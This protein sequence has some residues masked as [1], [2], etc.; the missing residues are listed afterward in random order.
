MKQRAIAALAA[1]VLAAT[2]C[3]DFLGSG[4]E[5]MIYHAVEVQVRDARTGRAIAAGARGEIVDGDYVDTLRAAS[6]T[7]D[8]LFSLA[9]G[10]GRRGFYTV[11][12]RHDGYVPWEQQGVRASADRCGVRTTRLTARLAPAGG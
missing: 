6:G 12:L 8:T 5:T 7:A 9:A 4:C 3:S 10:L 11:R 1:C 2:A